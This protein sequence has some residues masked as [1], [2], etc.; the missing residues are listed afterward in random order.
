MNSCSGGSDFDVIV[1]GAGPIGLCSAIALAQAEFKVALVEKSD[2]APIE[3][4]KHDGRGYAIS[5]G[6][7]RIL[8]NLGL[9]EHLIEEPSPIKSIYVQEQNTPFFL[10]FF[11]HDVR[12]DAMGYLVES[13]VLRGAIWKGYESVKDKLTLF[14]NAHITHL[15]QSQ[16]TVLLEVDVSGDALHMETPLLIACDGKYSE[17]KKKIGIESK[18]YEY[19]HHALV[20]RFK[21][22]RPHENMAYEYFYPE[23]PFAILP[24]K[25]NESSLVWCDTSEKIEALKS[26]NEASFS[27]L[28]EK[29]FP[30]LGQVEASCTRFSYPLTAILSETYSKGRVTL[31]GDAA[32]AIHPVAGQGLNLGMRGLGYLI[33]EIIHSRKNGGDWGSPFVLQAY[34]KALMRDRR[35][36]F[37]LTHGLIKLYE[38]D[39]KPLSMIRSLGLGIVNKIPVLKK[40]LIQEAMGSGKN[41]PNLMK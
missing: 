38:K 5:H 6:T 25:G 14:T 27:A 17:T 35:K 20:T 1:I 13:H 24:L 32:Q 22:E 4:P 40:K 21:H 31:L 8:K 3:H 29:R 15:E 12:E 9:W 11:A 41:L 2:L 36:F 26:L 33:E 30:H 37:C 19:G 10:T 18:V 34:E 28:L 39:F 7:M 23:G 16:H